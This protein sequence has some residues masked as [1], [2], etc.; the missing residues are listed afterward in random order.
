MKIA[1]LEHALGYNFKQPK[2]LERALTHRSWAHENLVGRSADEVRRAENESFEFVGDSVLGLA[3]A[4]R[5]FERNPDLAE[6]ALTLMKHRIVS[7]PTLA[8]IADG[9][10]LGGYLRV[11]RGEEQTGGRKK[12]ALLANT[13]EAVIAAVF[14][15]G[16]YVAA[17]SLV[18][19]LFA[20]EFRTATPGSSVDY[21]SLLQETLQADKLSAPVYSVVKTEGP[22]HERTFHVEANW[23]TGKASGLGRSRKLAEMAAAGEA[24]ELLKKQ[25]P[26]SGK[27]KPE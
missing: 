9:L 4:E 18:G 15:D 23:D 7:T 12:K 26:K 21:K 24:L 22:P 20:D 3:V 10:D 19:R 8:V 2:L 25:K 1:K 5:L 14:L 11:G 13:L 17:R 16:G 6:G 27:R